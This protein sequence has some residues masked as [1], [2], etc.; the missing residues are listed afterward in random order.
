MLD[1]MNGFRWVIILF[2]FFTLTLL[3]SCMPA[4]TREANQQSFVSS[5]TGSETAQTTSTYTQPAVSIYSETAQPSQIFTSTVLP[6]ASPTAR[7]TQTFMPIIASTVFKPPRSTRVFTPTT[8]LT[9]AAAPTMT[10]TAQPTGTA[11]PDPTVCPIATQEAFSVEPVTSPTDQLTQIITVYIGN[12][13]EVRIVTESGTFTVTGDFNISAAMVE[14]AL[15]PDTEHHLEVIAKVRQV[16]GWNNC[17]YG[18]YTL[19]T[20]TDK[21]GAP[22]I[23]IQGAPT[24]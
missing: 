13:E 22:L 5:S 3:V 16:S 21:M 2:L 20:R 8:S 14:I 9:T 18:G 19:S 11:E 4:A 12:G 17:I 24:P 6:T 10:E 1:S 23:I 15:L 7:P